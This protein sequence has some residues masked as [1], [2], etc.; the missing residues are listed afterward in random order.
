LVEIFNSD[1]VLYYKKSIYF[2]FVLGILIFHVPYMP[3]MLAVKLFIKGDI[4]GL[5]SVVLFT[6]NL[7]MYSCFIIGFIWSEK[8]F[9]Y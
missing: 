5:Y 2:W 9:N 4:Q 3:F 8:R 1:R 6:L 7:L